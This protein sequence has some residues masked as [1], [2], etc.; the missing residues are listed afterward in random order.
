VTALA[1][2]DGAVFSGGVVVPMA[3]G[4]VYGFNSTNGYVTHGPETF[5]MAGGKTGIRG[6]AGEEIVAPAAR[7][8]YGRLGVRMPGGGGNRVTNIYV[9]TPDADSFRRS[10]P[11][12]MADEKRRKERF[13]FE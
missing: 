1:F 13:G 11:H 12:I 8:K 3:S 2:A 6:E 9:Q 4:S 5:A 7:D 10:S